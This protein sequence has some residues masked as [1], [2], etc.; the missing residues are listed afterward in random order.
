M[1]A[2]I[3]L[4]LATLPL[5]L[6][7]PICQKPPP[8]ASNIPNITDCHDLINDVYAASKLQ[9][10]EPILWSQSPSAFVRNRKLPYSFK[11][12]FASSDCEFIVDALH[13]GSQDTFPTKLIGEAAEQI[14]QKCMEQ[15]IDGAETVGAVAVGPKRAIVVVLT[16]KRWNR[17]NMSGGTFGLNMTN[18]TLLGPGIILGLSPSLIEDG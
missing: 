11:S 12:L 2:T 6:C 7:E 10:D 9:G 4:L 17:S 8:H 14:V 5:S 1:F 13:E 3:S 18:V 15:G 16:K